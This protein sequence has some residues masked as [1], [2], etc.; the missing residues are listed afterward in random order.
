MYTCTYMRISISLQENEKKH[1]NK[2]MGKMWQQNKDTIRPFLL[3]W[4][5]SPLRCYICVPK[6]SLNQY[7]FFTL[8]IDFVQTGIEVLTSTIFENLSPSG[9][10]SERSYGWEG[11]KELAFCITFVAQYIEKTQ[12]KWWVLLQRWLKQYYTINIHAI[13]REVSTVP[14]W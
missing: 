14:T 9:G 10:F 8:Y 5:K 7:C 6:A 4:D 3:R 1:T 13:F 12:R 11:E 2:N